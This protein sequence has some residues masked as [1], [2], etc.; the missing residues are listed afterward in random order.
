AGHVSDLVLLDEGERLLGIEATH[1][2][3]TGSE[4]ISGHEHAQPE[5]VGEWQNEE[6]ALAAVAHRRAVPS[7]ERVRVQVSV[8]LHD[9]LRLAGCAARIEN[10]RDVGPFAGNDLT[11]RTARADERL[12]R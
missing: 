9:T 8:G 2:D 11:Q 3:A 10:G 4:E 12:V 7:V 1:Q 6:N 5:G